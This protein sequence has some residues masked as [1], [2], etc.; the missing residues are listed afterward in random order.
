MAEVYL[1]AGLDKSKLPIFVCSVHLSVAVVYCLAR[2]NVMVSCCQAVS[3]IV[4]ENRTGSVANVRL[5]HEGAG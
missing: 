3:A 1:A 2:Q 5:F 4:R